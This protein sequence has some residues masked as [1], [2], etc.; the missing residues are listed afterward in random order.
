[1]KKIFIIVMLVIFLPRG[2]FCLELNQ[3]PP[4]KGSSSLPYT[5][6]IEDVSPEI[7]E[8]IRE[9][10]KPGEDDV[11]V[12]SAKIFNNPKKTE[13]VVISTILHYSTDGVKWDEI[14]MEQDEKNNIIYVGKIPPQKEGT[15]VT[16]YISAH[17]SAGNTATEVVELRDMTS[18]TLDK[19]W[20]KIIEDED[21]KKDIVS[22]NLD[23]LST[24]LAYDKDWIYLKMEAQGEIT[25][26]TTHN[27][28]FLHT[29]GF[30]VLN[31]DMSEDVLGGYLIFYTPHLKLG[32]YPE[33]VLYS[34]GQMDFIYK[35]EASTEVK[36]NILTLKFRRSFLGS[37]P[38]NRLKIVGGTC[39][40][41]DINLRR[42]ASG[43]GMSVIEYLQNATLDLRGVSSVT[44]D[45]VDKFLKYITPTD[46]TSHTTVYL[47]SHTYKVE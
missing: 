6:I 39:G 11:V 42:G 23:V 38:T 24:Y 7:T 25:P 2:I 20:I 34:L 40:I 3:F 45:M 17:D 14:P 44:P 21:D 47:R 13:N 35:A 27:P 19:G 31:P 12:V 29:Y 5:N 18:D 9:L 22:D 32:G 37:N 46:A 15:Q 36:K 26:G 43:G 10:L 8:V 41:T 33:A 1:M 28:P 30:G 16:F 4:F